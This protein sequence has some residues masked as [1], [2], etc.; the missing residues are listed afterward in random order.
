MR[1][2]VVSKDMGAREN[3]AEAW[4]VPENSPTHPKIIL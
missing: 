3:G 2:K 1:V 4:V